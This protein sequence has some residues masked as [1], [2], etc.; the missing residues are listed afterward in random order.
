MHEEKLRRRRNSFFSLCN[1]IH[2]EN[3][4]CGNNVCN[5]LKR[6]NNRNASDKKGDNEWAQ[7]YYIIYNS[8]VL[9]GHESVEITD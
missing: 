4:Q 1:S 2:S 6:E 3:H 5:P 9:D 8:Y 7:E